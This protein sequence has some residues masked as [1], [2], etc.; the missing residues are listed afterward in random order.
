[1]P[2]TR[3]TRSD[4]EAALI[5]PCRSAGLPAPV[6][7]GWVGVLEVDLLFPA[8]RLVVEAD[9]FRY[10]GTRTAFERDRARDADLAR[11]GYRVLRFSDRQI[12][13]ES[14]TVVSTIAAVLGE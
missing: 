14:A 4:L 2:G 12:Q 3:P 8:A 7:N 11:A 13:R 1:M 6:V 9:G 5:A 10:H